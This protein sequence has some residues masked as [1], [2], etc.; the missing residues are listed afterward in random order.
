M[1]TFD[2]A[3]L[4]CVRRCGGIP[5]E[6]SS[7]YKRMAFYA[8]MLSIFLSTVVDLLFLFPLSLFLPEIA[9]DNDT[10]LDV[11]ITVS[12]VSSVSSVLSVSM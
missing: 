7:G 12:S 10:A 1:T 2:F 6:S 4:V 8:L 5:V 3:W 11:P 9:I